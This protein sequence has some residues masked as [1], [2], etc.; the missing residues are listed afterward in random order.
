[1]GYKQLVSE[2]GHSFRTMRQ[3]SVLQRTNFC[4][5][6]ELKIRGGW[7]VVGRSYDQLYS[8]E[9][10]RVESKFS[11]VRLFVWW[12]GNE[13]ILVDQGALT[14]WIDGKQTQVACM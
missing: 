6:Q 14:G 3:L 1:M 7:H 5:L 13:H 8:I 12:V 4:G 2:F 10:P 11:S 9:R